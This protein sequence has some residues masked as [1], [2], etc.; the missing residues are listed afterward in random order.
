[1]SEAFIGGEAL[2]AGALTRGQLRWRYTAV[3][4]GVYLP[5]RGAR[6]LH[7]N[8]VAA[9]LWTSRRGVVAGR[10][11]AALHG[12]LWVDDDTPVEL[13]APHTR[14]RPGVVVHEERLHPDEIC[15]IGDL[16][17]TTPARTAL[18][19]ARWLP[20]DAAVRHLDALARATGISAPVVLELAERYSRL[21]GVR[22]ARIALGL[23]DAGAQSPKETWL[24][25]MMIDDGY[26]R[27]ATQLPVTDGRH[28][29]FIDLGWEEPKIGLD[30]EGGHHLTERRTY[31]NDIGRYAM[32]EGQGWIDLRIV[33]EHSRSFILHRVRNAF[34]ERGLN[35]PNSA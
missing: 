19:I 26:R 24:R 8:T 4:P 28:R 12:A 14:P 13:I 23:M 20:R 6:S 16:P 11:A 30:Y 22:R 17:V 27:P 31:V 29:A 3:H 2:H 35:P 15:H 34:I 32:I 5:N 7:V 18:D 33:A 10:A 1:M 21:R 9:W 25:L